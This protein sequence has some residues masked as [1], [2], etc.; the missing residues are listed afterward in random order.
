[1]EHYHRVLS[2][3]LR[4]TLEASDG[5]FVG[6]EPTTLVQSGRR[7]TTPLGQAASKNYFSNIYNI[8]FFTME[9][10]E[11]LSEIG[12]AWKHPTKRVKTNS[13]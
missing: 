8:P 3:L 6:F 12:F 4:P 10:V 5:R 7:A 13:M 11:K 9:R 2:I 1:M